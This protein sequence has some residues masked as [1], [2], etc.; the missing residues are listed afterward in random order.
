MLNFLYVAMLR[1]NKSLNF[2]IKE[3][4]KV[5]LSEWKKQKTNLVMYI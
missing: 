5:C 2:L 4:F 1:K 3:M